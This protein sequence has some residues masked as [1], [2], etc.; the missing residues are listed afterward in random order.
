[1][2]RHLMILVGVAVLAGCALWGGHQDKTDTANPDTPY[3]K[4]D[5]AGVKATLT[6]RQTCEAVGGEIRRDGLAGHEI[7]VQTYA[8]AGQSCRDSSDC[9]GRC[10]ITGEFAD[11]DAPTD[12]G[13]CEVND[14]PFGCYQTVED[15]KATPGLCVD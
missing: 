4:V 13:Q 6:E 8:D 2:R 5:V 9:L 12:K 1:M 14:S 3:A 7:C 10:M 15:G 11:F